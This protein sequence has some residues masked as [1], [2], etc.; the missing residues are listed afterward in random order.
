MSEMRVHG[1]L[2]QTKL[3]TPTPRS[4]L[5]TRPHLCDRLT[6]GAEC[7]LT[8]L[9]APAGFGKTTL[10][11]EWLAQAGAAERGAAW[12][13][14]EDGDNDPAVFW[15]YVVTALD[16]ATN[17]LAASA[18]AAVETSQA[19]AETLL[20]TLVNDLN[21]LPRDITL[22]LDD[23]HVIESRAVLDGLSFL[24]EHLP[25]RLRLVIAS[26]ADPSMPL[27]RLRARG[28]LAE[29]RVADLRFTVDEAGTYL[30]RALGSPLT[31]DD[32]AAL[33]DRTEGWIAALQLAALSMK[34][35]ADV[36]AFIEHF[37]GDDR[38]IVDYLAEEVLQRLPSEVRTFLLHTSILT[39]LHA[40]L[41]DAITGNA[42]GKVM[43]ETLERGNLFLLPL[44][45]RRSWYRYH[46]LFAEVLRARLQDEQPDLVPALQRRASEWYETHGGRTEAINH[47][48]AGG[49]F[50]LAAD[51]AELAVPDTLRDR[52]ES[53]LCSWLDALPASVLDLRPVLN[54]AYV[55]ALMSTGQVER[56][57]PRLEAAT[58]WLAA[59]TEVGEQLEAAG[60]WVV[61]DSEQFKQL[62]SMIEMYQAAQ[63]LVG[64]DP[65]ATAAHA[66][67]AIE[68]APAGNQLSRA[69]GMALL[70]LASWT[71][72]DLEEA[73]HAYSESMDM[74][75]RAGH[76]SDV[77]GCAVVV[78]DIELAQGRL[79]DARRTYERAI[80]RVGGGDRPGLRGM[81][82]MHVGL[83][84][85]HRER[86]DLQAARNHLLR[87]Q[88]LG[89]H[90]GLP[91]YPHR[92]R[93]EMAQLRC[94][95]GDLDGAVALLDEAERVYTG[96]FHPDVGPIPALR[97]RI[98]VARGATD[99][100]LAWAREY[101]VTLDDDLSYLREFEHITLAR[102][103]LVADGGAD[104]ARL[105]PAM[106]L[107]ERLLVAA[108]AGRRTRSVIEILVLQALAQQARADTGGAL[109]ALQQAVALAEPEGH[110]RIFLDE[111]PSIVP[112]L[113]VQAKRAGGYARRLLAAA[114]TGQLVPPTQGLIDPLSI[115]ELDVLRLLA[116]D[117]TGPEIAR[118]LVVSLS[119]VRT[120][121]K[122]IY[123]KLGVNSRRAAVRLSGELELLAGAREA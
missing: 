53:T 123:L 46:H 3:H 49:H 40:P 19:S 108:S 4:G 41:C 8:L 36:S 112:L 89:A 72:G 55:G 68:L 91:R 66:R 59:T 15:S 98:H 64:G 90:A 9:S 56:A 1:H 27:A 78:A 44:D 11:A 61:V 67:R 82:D 73:H 18:R 52:R 23:F 69:G 25:P 43:L 22:V 26:R 102:I 30:E 74:M 20:P 24:L 97:A 95:D 14:L 99:D 70:G 45:N 2:L 83:S 100:A 63:A 115:R 84:G 116:T 60:E 34:G 79:G 31:R 42:T 77:L 120:H 47:A 105:A 21:G 86:N 62:P 80:E 96:D 71:N 103:L 7:A 113:G 37:A 88:E 119:T 28:Q 13:S 117:L 48:L 111:G 87:A 110:V 65:V 10:L 94:A 109:E 16:A 5:V 114:G 122:N 57:A 101:R 38:Y 85:V 33:D 39:R 35:R 106:G 58:R 75:L 12:V 50:E 93:V 17:G 32:V 118:E 81:A 6:E 51:L 107:L 92:W 121:T 54:V 104:A 76:A 29:V